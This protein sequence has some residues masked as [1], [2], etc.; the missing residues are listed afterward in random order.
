MD[1]RTTQDLLNRLSKLERRSVRFRR[2][3]ITSSSPVHVSLGGSAVPYT[4]VQTLVGLTVAIGDQVLCLVAGN[5]ICVIG[6]LTGTGFGGGGGGGS[7]DANYVHTQ[8]IAQT[9]WTVTHNL[10]K[11]VSVEAV[12]ASGD[13]IEGNIHYNSDNQ[14]TLTFEAAVSGAAYF[15]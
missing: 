8:G 1:T 13:T 9:T 12:D 5:S 14:V 3:E 7:G 6:S 10:G 2:G 11:R 4:N 15:N